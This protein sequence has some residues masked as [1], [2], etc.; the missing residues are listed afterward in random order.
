MYSRIVVL[1]ILNGSS[2]K[3]ELVWALADFVNG[4]MAVPDLLALLAV[5]GIV[6]GIAR[7]KKD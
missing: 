6:A 7:N 3:V 5:S 4:L 1:F 2:L